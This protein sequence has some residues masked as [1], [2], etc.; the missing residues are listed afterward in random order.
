[1]PILAEEPVSALT[2]A[3]PTKFW[4]PILA[5]F[6]MP[7]MIHY[8]SPLRLARVLAVAIA[9]AEQA[10]IEGHTAGLVKGTEAELQHI[11]QLREEVSIVIEETLRNSLSWRAALRGFLRGRTCT[12]LRCIREVQR[13]ETY[14]EILKESNLRT[15]SNLN[16]RAIFLERR[17]VGP[18][19]EGDQARRRTA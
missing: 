17:P 1:M 3:L 5:V 10:F 15:E 18:G 16:P 12:L 4:G 11:P 13:F 19:Y 7:L 2:C 8:M 14:I 6:A 9:H